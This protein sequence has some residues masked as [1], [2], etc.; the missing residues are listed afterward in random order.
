[1]KPV[2]T[3]P[4]EDA[5]TSRFPEFCEERGQKYPAIVRLWENAWAEFVPFLQFDAETRWNV[6]TAN[7]VWVLYFCHGLGSSYPGRCS[8]RVRP[9]LNAIGP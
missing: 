5:A 3:A 8:K 4:A 7:A 6:C 9:D 2:Y 1:M